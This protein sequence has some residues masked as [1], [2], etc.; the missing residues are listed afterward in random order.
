V[1]ATIRAPLGMT[2]AGAKQHVSTLIS[3]LGQ[4]LERKGC[5][6]IA[7]NVYEHPVGKFLHLHS[8]LSVPRKFLPLVKEWV[9]VFDEKPRLKGEFVC[10]VD[11]HAR[12][13]VFNSRHSDLL[14]ILKEHRFA[15]SEAEKKRHFWEKSE[16]ITGAR[17]SFTKTAREIIMQAEAEQQ[18]VEPVVVEIAVEQQKQQVVEPVTP[19]QQPEQIDIERW[20]EEHD[21]AV[22]EPVGVEIAPP[23]PAM[24]PD[25]RHRRP[26]REMD[27]PDGQAE[28]LPRPNI[29]AMIDSIGPNNAERARL[30]GV[31][32]AHI[33]TMKAGFFRPGLDVWRKLEA[34]AA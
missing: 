17:V 27:Q 33:R 28:F 3:R 14:Y 18:P 8:L 6:Y 1:F 29:R 12:P 15:G 10:N 2:Q 25:R 23:I 13:A 31:S 7:L 5:A 9:D 21:A 4:K 24:A 16:S 30:L 32:E 22:V 20:I 34:L 26:A 19:A 11:I